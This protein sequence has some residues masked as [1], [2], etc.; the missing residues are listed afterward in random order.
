[1]SSLLM[2]TLTS[3]RGTIFFSGNCVIVTGKKEELLQDAVAPSVASCNS[4]R[5]LSGDLLSEMQR[6]CSQVV[7][8]CESVRVDGKEERSITVAIVVS[9]G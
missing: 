1:M 4:S 5:L 7:G 2:S 3:S 6:D 9:C 8:K